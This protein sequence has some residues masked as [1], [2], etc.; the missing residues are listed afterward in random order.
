LGHVTGLWVERRAQTALAYGTV[1][2]RVISTQNRTRMTQ[3]PCRTSMPPAFHPVTQLKH[4]MKSVEVRV[5]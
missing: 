5:S 4:P 3:S 2:P 1:S